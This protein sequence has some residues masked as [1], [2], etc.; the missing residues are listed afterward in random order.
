VYTGIDAVD[1]RADQ[2]DIV[3]KTTFT[4]VP[5]L[6]GLALTGCH[7]SHTTKDLHGS[8]TG[9]GHTLNSRGVNH[10]EKTLVLSVDELGLVSGTSGWRLIS[11]EGGHDGE[12]ETASDTEEV[13]GTFDV[14]SGVFYLVET[15]ESGFL[16][17]HVLDGGEIMVFHVQPGTKPVV[18][19]TRMNRAD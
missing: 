17:G 7:Q 9:T 14:E 11:G 18:S 3:Q 13:L 1:I 5:L 6:A 16:H 8:W 12:I 4:I 2:G 10:T 15:E 19:S